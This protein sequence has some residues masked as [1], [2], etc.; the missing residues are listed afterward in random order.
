MLTKAQIK[1]YSGPMFAG[2]TT[3]LIREYNTN[4]N[5]IAI[6]P[7]YDTRWSELSSHDGVLIP[8]IKVKTIK[9]LEDILTKNPNITTL[10][11]DEI[12]FFDEP[13]FA[14][15]IVDF[16]V[17]AKRREIS[18]YV[19]GLDYDW[20]GNAFNLTEALINISDESIK[21][22]G[23]CSCG[24][25][26][27]RTQKKILSESIFDIGAENMYLPTCLSCFKVPE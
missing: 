25:P 3:A 5:S 7:S 8:S 20:K 4:K 23:K 24:N 11:F 18:S 6:R 14:G 27:V 21:L 10:L 22:S 26:S 1:V 16:I 13:M 19:F 12:H 9:D 15:N 2:K 17:N